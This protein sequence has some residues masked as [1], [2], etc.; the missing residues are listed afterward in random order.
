VTTKT[1]LRQ[2]P[3]S[4]STTSQET[5]DMPKPNCELPDCDKPRYQG[6]TM[7]GSHYMKWYRRGDPYWTQP[8][9]HDHTLKGQRFGSLIVDT[10]IRNRGW[11]CRCDCGAIRVVKAGELNAGRATSCGDAR[12]HWRHDTVTYSSIHSRIRTD[13]GPARIHPCVS[14]G[15]RAAQ[16]SYN[17][18]DPDELSHDD[19]PYGTSPA[20]YSPRCVQCHKIFDLQ[21]INLR[22]LDSQVAAVANESAPGVGKISDDSQCS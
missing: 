5:T 20:Y 7:C 11:Q 21:H 19:M 16:W 9:R 13:R 3:L 15:R 12:I 2:Q 1:L 18:N 10:Y 6:H 8:S 17:H 14:C 4:R 22:I